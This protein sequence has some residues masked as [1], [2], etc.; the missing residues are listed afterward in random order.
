VR[1]GRARRRLNQ[2]RLNQRGDAIAVWCLGLALL[3]LPLG[4]VSL[5]VWHAISAQRH[6]Q[7]LA[8]DAAAAG[9]S[10][11]DTTKFR[12]TGKA[13]LDP[14][15]ATELA[16]TNLATQSDLPTLNGEQITVSP[17]DSTITV[18]LH[19]QVRLTLLSLS[20]GNQSIGIAG[21][22]SSAPRASGDPQ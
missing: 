5:D 21:S 19:Q 14:S 4:G 17:D 9:A 2:R 6:L 8:E 22:A 15:L 18:S 7:A 13:V 10:G 1:S 16:E 11:L 3:L 12:T 20:L